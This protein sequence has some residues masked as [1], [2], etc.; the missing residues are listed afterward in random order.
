MGLLLPVRNLRRPDRLITTVS[1]I[2]DPLV[3]VTVPA[4]F[5]PMELLAHTPVTCGARPSPLQPPMGVSDFN[6]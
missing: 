5:S 6:Q 1:T 2:R 4:T 3:E